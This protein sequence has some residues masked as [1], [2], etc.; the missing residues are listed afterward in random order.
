MS[1]SSVPPSSPSARGQPG[2][3]GRTA[4]YPVRWPWARGTAVSSHRMLT[5]RLP[6]ADGRRASWFQCS[7]K[8]VGVPSLPSLC[9]PPAIVVAWLP[10][11]PWL[12]L[13]VDTAEACG[14]AD[15]TPGRRLVIVGAPRMERGV[16]TAPDAATC[17]SI[18]GCEV[19]V[20]SVGCK[21]CRVCME[22]CSNLQ[23]EKNR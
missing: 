12:P 9:V 2:G 20:G 10:W 11:L 6:M 7:P 5:G 15:S 21:V 1:P 3:S 23:G 8:A 18:R 17:E 13:G 4:R 22:K 14:L 16:R 19:S